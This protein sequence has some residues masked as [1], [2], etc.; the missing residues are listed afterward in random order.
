MKF[1]D[2]YEEIMKWVYKIKMNFFVINE[3]WRD[4]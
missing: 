1:G 4:K 2:V 3:I